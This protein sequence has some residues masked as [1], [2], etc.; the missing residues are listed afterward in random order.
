MQMQSTL[1]VDVENMTCRFRLALKSVAKQ[2]LFHYGH[3][4]KYHLYPPPSIA[5]K[6]NEN[7]MIA[8][9]SQFGN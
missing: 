5:L 9:Q 1:A 8:P 6:P 3:P 7:K 2:M 4:L